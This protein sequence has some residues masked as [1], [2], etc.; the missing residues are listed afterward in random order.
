MFENMAGEV[1]FAMHEE[2][3]A[4]ANGDRLI[5]EAARATTRD[6]RIRDIR[7]YRAMLAHGL[8][9][10]ATRLAPRGTTP[11]VSSAQ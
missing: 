7:H 9:A 1:G 8:I 10:V 3:L 4:Q 6:A 5:A 11:Q 2:R